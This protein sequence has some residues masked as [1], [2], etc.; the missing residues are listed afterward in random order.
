MPLYLI[1]YSCQSFV[2]L[3]RAASQQSYV[4]GD[5]VLCRSHRG[6]EV[7]EILNSVV[8]D[9]GALLADSLVQ[10]PEGDLLRHLT[11]SDDLLWQ[12]LEKNK[13]KAIAECQSWLTEKSP[14]TLLLDVELLFDG[15]EIYFYFLG[16]I[17]PNLHDYLE[18]LSKKYEATM[19]IE[20][21]AQTLEAGCGPGCGT[22]AATGGCGTGG[23][24]CSTCSIASACRTV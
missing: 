4:L 10:Q 12:R 1:R 22:E 18:T 23:G 6:L 16:E 8:L 21:F 15:S 17:A 19:K 13:D 5:R 24:G 20:S 2:G 14:E 9:E 3:F 11:P 7:G